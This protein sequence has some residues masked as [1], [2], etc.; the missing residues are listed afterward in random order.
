MTKMEVDQLTVA[1]PVLI[2]P[3][4]RRPKKVIVAITIVFLI[5]CSVALFTSVVIGYFQHGTI[6]EEATPAKESEMG[7]SASL[8]NLA[9]LLTL[10]FVVT[11]IIVLLIKYGMTW[12]LR[13][14]MIGVV[15]FMIFTF[16]AYIVAVYQVY[17]LIQ[18]YELGISEV[19]YFVPFIIPVAYALVII[20]IVAYLFS[21]IKL[22]GINTRNVILLL[23]VVWAAVWMAWNSGIITPIV[24]LIG[25]ALYDLYSVFRGPLRDLA[26][27]LVEPSSEKDVNKEEFGV[28][29]GLG[30]VFFYSFAIAYSC[31]VLT[32]IE[33]LV[34]VFILYL[35]VVATFWLLFKYNVNALPA[36]PIPV[37]SAVSLIILFSFVI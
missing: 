8:V 7:A 9:Y 34:I 20:L 10:I 29:L 24:I 11:F 19:V 17:I 12:L 28:I 15:I 16:T 27:F 22:R 25:F 1:L 4:E 13:A 3:V 14:F 6:T 5:T 30:D 31:A 23:N 18:L 36:L 37:L 33:T 21:V 2:L 35:G 32:T 26:E